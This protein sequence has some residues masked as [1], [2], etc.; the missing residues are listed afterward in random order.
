MKRTD[1]FVSIFIGVA[2]GIVIVM[3]GLPNLIMKPKTVSAATGIEDVLTLTLNSHLKWNTVKG[4]A[5][6]VWYGPKGETQIYIDTFDILQPDKAYVDI[7]ST[8][9]SGNEG[10]WISDGTNFYTI[11]KETKT[12]IENNIPPFARD[13]SLLP[14]GLT[15]AESTNAIYRH[16][17]ALIMPAPVSEYLYPQWFGQGG[18][19]YSNVGEDNISNRNTWIVDHKKG[20]DEVKAWIDKET[21]VILKYNQ[22]TGGRL[23]LNVTFTKIEYNTPIDNTLFSVP[24]GFTSE[25]LHK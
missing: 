13:F 7:V 19:T 15:E 8:N 21:G 2:L 24:A 20:Q 11:N 25:N 4:E 22:Q 9:D 16:P 18:G 1:W 3:T 14:K 6:F 10:M 23:V 5:Q 12:F 17:F